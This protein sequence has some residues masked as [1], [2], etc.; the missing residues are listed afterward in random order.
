MMNSLVSTAPT[1]TLMGSFASPGPSERPEP[2]SSIMQGIMPP[3]R[4]EMD[5]ERKPRGAVSPNSKFFNREMHL[6]FV[7]LKCD[8]CLTTWLKANSVYFRSTIY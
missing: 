6:Q 5:C 8:H 4:M 7:K 2:S 1:I 3:A